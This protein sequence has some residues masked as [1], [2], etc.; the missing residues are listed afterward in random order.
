MTQVW[1][2]PYDLTAKPS[3]LRCQFRGKCLKMHNVFVVKESLAASLNNYH[4]YMNCV[5]IIW[6]S[7]S[8]NSS[9]K[10]HL[11]SLRRLSGK[12]GILDVSQPYRP[13][14]PVTGIP[15]LFLHINYT[16]SE[17]GATASLMVEMINAF[18]VIK[19]NSLNSGISVARSVNYLPIISFVK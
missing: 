1:V 3:Q 14:W 7:H 18:F 6:S 17:M 15:L 10:S 5:Y 2:V 11:P 8:G 12:C 19:V 4:G 16:V 9:L 13:S